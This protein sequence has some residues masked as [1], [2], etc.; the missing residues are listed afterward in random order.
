MGLPRNNRK[1]NEIFKNAR[2][3]DIFEFNGEY[4]VNMLTGIP[5]L[6]RFFHRK[7]FYPKNN[8]ILGY[9][10]FFNNMKWGSFFLEQRSYNEGKVIVI[11]YDK[12]ENSFITDKIRDYVRRVDKE[13]YLGRFNYLFF[14]KPLF[15]GYFSLTK[16]QTG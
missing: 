6:K 11:N 7:V 16:N 5:S 1:L 9:N 12:K 14:G 10:L 4:F 13:I 2:T 8:K 3:P 15:L